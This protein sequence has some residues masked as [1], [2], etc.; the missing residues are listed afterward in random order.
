MKL[1]KDLTG[2][3]IGRLE[4]LRPAER[5]A[6]GTRWL[7][8]C[9]CGTYTK[10]FSF[11]LTNSNA[12]QSCGCLQREVVAA[13]STTHGDLRYGRRSPEH[14]IWDAMIQRCTNPNVR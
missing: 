13:A 2:M 6:S 14:R 4:V 5:T 11:S 12:T 3:R 8:L 9:A 1:R 10:I 7:C